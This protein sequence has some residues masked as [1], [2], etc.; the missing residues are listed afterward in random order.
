VEI[1]NGVP[2]G[3]LA[4]AAV[5]DVTSGFTRRPS[6]RVAG[7]NQRLAE[8]LAG[9]LGSSVRLRSPV[10]A[11]EH[12]HESVRV[13]T[14]DGLVAGDA[15]IVAVP[16]AVLRELPFSPP[17]PDRYRD[18][19]RRAGLA[20]NA[21]LHVPLTRPAAASAVQS[22]P[23]RFWTWTATDASG[24]VQPVLHA[25]GGTKAGLAA[26]AVANGPAR[27]ASRVAA[28]RPELALDT[29]R[30]LVTTWNDD[31]WAGES[32]SAATVD[33]ADGDDQL[34]AAPLGRVH[35]AG[36]HTAGDWAGLME[37]ALRSGARAA[38][39]VLGRPG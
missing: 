35:F 15:V 23:E 12:D 7:G 4:A 25:F 31:R 38:D 24:Q 10:R 2:A 19:W 16:M 18:A 30:A 9:R 33:V 20:H 22:V 11:V 36:E 37:G 32:Y 3:V 26:L 1:T 29:G 27:W 6:W 21:K 14:G 17:V 13:L 34:I 28:L 8:G 39:E 5:R